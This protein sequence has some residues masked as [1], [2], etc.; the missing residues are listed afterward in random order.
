MNVCVCGSALGSNHM[1]VS[2]CVCAGKAGAA[3]GHDASGVHQE[4]SGARRL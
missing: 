2:V 4:R 3:G 1:C